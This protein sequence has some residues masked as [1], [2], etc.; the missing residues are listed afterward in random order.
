M[1]FMSGMTLGNDQIQNEASLTTHMATNKHYILSS[2]LS[3]E[4]EGSQTNNNN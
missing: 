4:A 3:S 1:A 2:I